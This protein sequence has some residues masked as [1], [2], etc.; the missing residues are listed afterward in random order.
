MKAVSH[1]GRRARLN[2]RRRIRRMTHHSVEWIEGTTLFRYKCKT[3]AHVSTT[4]MKGRTPPGPSGPAY[5]KY[6]AYQNQGAGAQGTCP[7]CTK[8]ARDEKYPL[9]KITGE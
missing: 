1:P 6:A 9:S 7:A 2:L 3:C 5:G 8:R 4:D